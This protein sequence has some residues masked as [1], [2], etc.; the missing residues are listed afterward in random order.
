MQI[1]TE[2]L[3]IYPLNSEEMSLWI[4]DLSRLENKLGCSYCAE[5]VEGVFKEVVQSQLILA[6]NDLPEF[7]LWYTFWFL[8]RKS[9]R[10][11]V[12]SLVFK[13]RPSLGQGD[14]EVGYGL[15][16]DFEHRGYMATA[17]KKICEWAKK[18]PE[19]RFVTAETEKDKLAS[20]RLLLRC[21]FE[22]FKETEQSYW[23]RF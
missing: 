6:L 19:V 12:G 9:D 17:V 13:G 16:K 5:S 11:V 14:V 2:E 20:Q 10:K 8:I 22:K 7:W 21:G 1:D 15:G 4:N 23:Y 18:Q 3:L